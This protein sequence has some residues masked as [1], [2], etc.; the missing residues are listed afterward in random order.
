MLLVGSGPEKKL[1]NIKERNDVKITGFVSNVVPYLQA[2]DIFV[3]PSSTETTS[4]ATVEA[5]SC[6]L[7][8]IVTKVGYLKEY[9][10]DRK[11]GVFFPVHN[12]YVL[13]RKLEKLISNE[14]GRKMLG[15]NARKTVIERF[16]W[17][18]T[19]EQI[20]KALDMF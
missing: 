19:V 8:V 18:K 13:R 14:P 17:D 15:E 2:M 20:K 4:L 3:L 16:S 7:P 9:V 11:N 5:M 6:S 10:I 12:D 1:Q